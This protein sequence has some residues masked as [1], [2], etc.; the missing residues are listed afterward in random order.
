MKRFLLALLL[1]VL[2]AVGAH[3]GAPALAGGPVNAAPQS[4]WSDDTIVG[5]VLR[6]VAAHCQPDG[7]LG[8]VRDTPEALLQAAGV[9]VYAYTERRGPGYLVHASTELHGLE[10]ADTLMHELAH[11]VAYP[12]DAEF[13]DPATCGGHG[14]RWGVAY[15]RVFRAVWYD[16]GDPPPSTSPS[17]FPPDS[18]STPSPSPS[19]GSSRQEH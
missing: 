17:P 6:R 15:A 13:M 9:P 2:P 8:I 18:P 14:S 11:A 12:T 5:L 3:P 16:V 7:P 19:S 10:L 4:A 1:A